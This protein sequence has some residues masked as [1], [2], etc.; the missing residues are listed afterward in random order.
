MF[1]IMT[2]FKPVRV[3]TEEKRPVSSS[4]ASLFSVFAVFLVFSVLLSAALNFSNPVNAAIKKSIEVCS[5]FALMLLH[6]P[7]SSFFVFIFGKLF[8]GKGDFGQILS[9][10]YF[11]AASSSLF[12]FLYFVP[13]AEF[14]GIVLLALGLLLYFY[15]VNECIQAF[16]ALSNT[17]TF[18]M[19]LFYILGFIL[20]VLA[21]LYLQSQGIVLPMPA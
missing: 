3:L 19:L 16:F 1:D 2:F 5:L 13:F 20:P 10:F 15:F 9:V 21:V 18:F 4:L 7:I 12:M 11:L 6:V 14:A 8:S 17:K